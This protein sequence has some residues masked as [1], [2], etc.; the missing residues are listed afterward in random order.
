MVKSFI[1]L[2]SAIRFHALN[3]L[4]LLVI[5]RRPTVRKFCHMISR[6]CCFVIYCVY[7]IDVVYDSLL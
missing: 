4:Q 6:L 2:Y 5:S 1:F 7:R 3:L